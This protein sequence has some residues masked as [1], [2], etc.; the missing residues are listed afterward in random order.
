MAYLAGLPARIPVCP[1]PLD[2]LTGVAGLLCVPGVIR[3]DRVWRRE[4]LAVSA[5]ALTRCRKGGHDGRHRSLG[6]R[7]QRAA[8]ATVDLSQ[9]PQ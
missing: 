9:V 1:Y 5:V 7:E 8:G 6:K 4:S 3:E 2:D